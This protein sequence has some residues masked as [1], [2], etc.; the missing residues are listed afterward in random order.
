MGIVL[1]LRDT[2]SRNKS[3]GCPTLSAEQRMDGSG[4]P[5]RYKNE[6]IGLVNI[7]II[8]RKKSIV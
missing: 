7:S 2:T 3:L 8:K 5:I 4:K 6:N 1:P